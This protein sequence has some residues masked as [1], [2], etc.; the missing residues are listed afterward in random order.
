VL[1]VDDFLATGATISA[2]V[3]LVQHAGAELVGIGTV[4]EKVFEGGRA[5]LEAL[6]VPVVSL[7]VVGDMSDGRI[8]L[9]C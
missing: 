1:V 8:S 6:G 9:L 4:V 5:D 3:R 7:A 2:L